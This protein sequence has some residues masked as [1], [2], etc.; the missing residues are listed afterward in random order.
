MGLAHGPNALTRG[1]G[2]GALARSPGESPCRRGSAQGQRLFRP[3]DARPS[4]EDI[5]A[6]V[7]AHRAEHRVEPIC[8]VRPVAPSTYRAPETARADACPRTSSIPPALDAASLARRCRPR[9]SVPSGPAI[10][11]AI[12]RRGPWRSPEVVAYAQLESA[13]SRT[14]VRS[15]RSKTSCPPRRG[16]APS[17]SR[18]VLRRRRRARR[19]RPCGD[20]ERFRGPSFWSSGL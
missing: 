11:P 18:R 10:R 12:R 7:D 5:G 17:A 2:Q 14:A 13:G 6:S 1:A 19:D 9:S 8:K 16:C 3:C 4:A 20:P 15:S